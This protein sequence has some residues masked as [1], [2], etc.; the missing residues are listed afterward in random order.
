VR[1]QGGGDTAFRFV[2]D[3][4]VSAFYWIDGPLAYALIGNVPREALLELSRIA[5]EAL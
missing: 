2:S 1:P 4:G 3:R 5:Y